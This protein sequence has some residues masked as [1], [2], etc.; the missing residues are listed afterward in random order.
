M[1]ETIAWEPQKIADLATNLSRIGNEYRI[2]IAQ[3]YN[4]FNELGAQEKWVG[5]NYNA[6]ATNQYNL[7]RSHFENWANALQLEIPQKLA[8]IAEM[9]AADNGGIVSYSITS[10][11][12]EIKDITL[13]VEKADGTTIVDMN[14]VEQ[15]LK[16]N[17]PEYCEEANSKADEYFNQFFSIGC[18]KGNSAIDKAYTEIEGIII[19]TKKTLYNFR[20]NAVDAIEKTADG[21]NFTNEETTKIATNI[22]ENLNISDRDIKINNWTDNYHKMEEIKEKMES[23]DGSNNYA[24]RK[25]L[26]DEYS[27]YQA[28][29]ERDAR[30]LMEGND[31]LI[32]PG[33]TE[34]K[35]IMWI[36]EKDNEVLWKGHPKMNPDGTVYRDSDGKSEWIPPLNA[37]IK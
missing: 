35:A 6:L 16:Q 29:A 27:R 3:I 32:N 4:S 26:L 20:C 5:K 34:H 19:K 22:R 28:K 12:V 13:T 36:R 33:S 2:S 9:Q 14:M 11:S 18:V 37:Q 15:E 30:D 23:L 24:E 25:Q 1:D 8:S 7:V 31:R 21:I 10:N 17:L